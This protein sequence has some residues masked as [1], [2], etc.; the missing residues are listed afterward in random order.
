M[1][2]LEDIFPFR[3]YIFWSWRLTH[4]G[5]GRI[6]AVFWPRTSKKQRYFG[7]L[8][9]AEK[10]R[11]FGRARACAKQNS[12]KSDF[13]GKFP[14]CI[15]HHVSFSW[16]CF[17]TVLFGWSTTSG[18]RKNDVF[19]R[20]TIRCFLAPESHG[21]DG[22]HSFR[23]YK[24][25][26]P[27]LANSKQQMLKSIQQF[28]KCLL[29]SSPLVRWKWPTQVRTLG[30]LWGG[31]DLG[32]MQSTT[33]AGVSKTFFRASEKSCFF[34][35]QLPD[36]GPKQFWLCGWLASWL[37]GYLAGWLP[38]WLRWL[39]GNWL[40][41]CLAGYLAISYLVGWLI[42]RL[43]WLSGCLSEWLALWLATWLSRWLVGHLA[44]WL[45]GRLIGWWLARWLADCGVVCWLAFWFGYLA[46][47]LP[48]YLT[49][50]L[51]GW[52]AIWLAGW[53][54][55]WLAGWISGLAR[56]L[57]AGWQTDGH[58]GYLAGYLAGWLRGW[59]AGDLAIWLVLWLG[60]WLPDWFEGLS[61]FRWLS[62]YLVG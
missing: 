23:Q 28:L 12:K 54:A 39:F 57:P 24:R 32:M 60:G 47:C 25:S 49:I 33:S 22:Y 9:Y 27:K 19:S 7:N 35:P 41:G 31:W 30:I 34:G 38:D 37:A 15:F 21:G 58:A 5:G 26:A 2:S 52:L 13:F 55:N 17:Y 18:C 11:F 53:L 51:A 1:I 3:G 46:G 42:G 8:L 6:F 14:G 40:C 20:E 61:G 44:G 43:T 62:G 36:D 16:L 59:L 10:L 56:W 4:R 29:I 50:W 48:A 45:S